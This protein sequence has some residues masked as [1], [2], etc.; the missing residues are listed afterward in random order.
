MKGIDKLILKLVRLIFL[1]NIMYNFRYIACYSAAKT[2]ITDVLVVI[3][4]SS[5]N[6]IE[7][8]RKYS[9]KPQGNQRVGI[10]PTERVS[11]S[12]ASA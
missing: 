3:E 8:Y 5:N 2:T 11:S 12:F 9:L 4:N 6:S 7:L 1:L 10:E